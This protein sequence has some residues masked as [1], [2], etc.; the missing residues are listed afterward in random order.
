[1]S[2]KKDAMLCLYGLLIHL[3]SKR[4][5]TLSLELAH[6]NVPNPF[7]KHL[8]AKI[9]GMEFLHATEGGIVLIC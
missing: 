3:A 1:M 8:Q 7:G 6:N 4:K 9:F 2:H 5:V